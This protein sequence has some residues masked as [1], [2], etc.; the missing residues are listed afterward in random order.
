[1]ASQK[2]SEYCLDLARAANDA[3]AWARKNADLVRGELDGLQLELRRARRAFRQCARAAGRKMCVGVFG[4]SQ[5]G[6]S[7][8]ISALARD[9]TGGLAA[10]FGG[11]KHDFISEINPEGGKES[12]GLVTRFTMTRPDGL[13]AG[14]PVQIRLLGETD[15]VKIIANTYYADC[16]HKSIPDAEAV[17]AVLDALGT[18]QHQGAPHVDLDALEDL[19]EYLLRDFQAKPRVQELERVYW[20][21]ALEMGPRLGLQDRVAL[22]SLIWDN[23]PQFTELCRSLTDALEK[24]SFSDVAFCS[25][26]ALVPRSGSIIDVAML[27]GLG[28]SD[29]RPLDVSAGQGSGTVSLPKAVVA[30]LTAELT[31]VMGE[32]PD[33][34]FEHTD[35]LDFP[36]Y[37]SRYKLTDLQREL[38][39]PGM[40]KELFLRGKVAYLFQRYCAEKELTGMLLCI[41]PSN[42]EV[43]DLPGVINDWVV[44]SHGEL[45]ESRKDKAES[46][47]F[48]LTKF[49]MEFEDKAGAP[50]V[51][52]RWD[53]R[54]HASLLDFFGKQHDWPTVWDGER[55]FNNLFLLRNPNFKFKTALEYDDGNQETGLRKDAQKLV[56]SLQ[57][58][59]LD[60]RLVT[61]H[62]KD[63]RKSW[64]A[65]M[66]LNDGGIS[67]IR[68][69]LRPLCNPAV[70]K[71]QLLTSLQDRRRKLFQRLSAFYKTD[72]KEEERRQKDMFSREIL[73]HFARLLQEQR[74]GQF[75]SRLVVRDQELYDLYFEARR[76]FLAAEDGGRPDEI[77]VNIG[78]SV[79]AADVFA[80]LFGEDVPAVAGQ[81]GDNAVSSGK[82]LSEAQ[83]FAELIISSWCGKMR[84]FSDDPRMQREYGIPSRTLAK[85]IDELMAGLTRL[86]I[87]EEMEDA[88]RE[89]AAYVNTAKEHI[90]WQQAARA[91]ALLN[92]YMNWLGFNS[93]L[94]G[95]AERTVTMQSKRHILFEPPPP[96]DGC[97]ALPELQPP[98]EKTWCMD[99][100]R[101]FYALM[102]DNINFDGE[103]TV[104]REQN[105]S[106]GFVL[107]TFDPQAAPPDTEDMEPPHESTVP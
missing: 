8:L 68:D 49:D 38:Q 91:S 42:Q 20:Q 24:L 2:L 10:L 89:A 23:V 57:A 93:R 36:G 103:R 99:W 81:N 4:P 35:L 7:Y 102:M 56:D 64:E 88:L 105:A 6:K 3:D 100:M 79:D 67:L 60:S 39:K 74:M 75:F 63:P 16:E 107:K 58:A 54:L 85:F 12:T 28:E 18:K 19:R 65:A 37:R 76:R 40:T 94:C 95:P 30:A 11:A 98:F 46:L 34:Y 45:P 52:F 21:R 86:R 72:D 14:F 48:I 77:Q 9:K 87:A 73:A 33:D 15:I 59:F 1:M 71:T 82:R 69:A 61:R 26:E 78:S 47:Y 96:F 83:Y 44:S 51:E 62:F 66:S 53:N 27:E 104:N 29:D 106:L 25:V 90:V 50:S 97:P 41:G 22:Y 80:E 55:A 101:A 17:T 92:S 70:K 13:P 32:K 43:Q 84:D 5:A 31:I